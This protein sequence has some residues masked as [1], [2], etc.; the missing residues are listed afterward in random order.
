MRR[1]TRER[2]STGRCRRST[3]RRTQPRAT[4]SRSLPA[5][6]RTTGGSVAGARAPARVVV[7]VVRAVG[8]G[9]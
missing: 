9:P 7:V 4:C 5:A 8:W 3:T 1:T 2:S 6:S